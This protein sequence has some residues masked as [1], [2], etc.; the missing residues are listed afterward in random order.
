MPS[1][2]KNWETCSALV[3][4]K[5]FKCRNVIYQIGTSN[6]GFFG[7]NFSDRNWDFQI[8]AWNFQELETSKLEL[9]VIRISQP[10]GLMGLE[11]NRVFKYQKSSY[12]DSNLKSELQSLSEN[13]G[14]CSFKVDNAG[15]FFRAEHTVGAI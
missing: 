1:N 4:R 5:P 11:E 15:I 14:Y 3:R 10:V 12:E 13:F 2:K 7:L 9:F 8:G 6:F